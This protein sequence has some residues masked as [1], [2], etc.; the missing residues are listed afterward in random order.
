MTVAETEPDACAECG[1]AELRQD[2]DVLDTWFSSALY[3]FA[4][5]GW[6]DETPELARYYPGTVLTTARDIIFLWIARMIFSGLELIG[7]EPFRDA[8]IHSYLL[9]PEG[10][11]MSRT[12]RHRHRSRGG[13]GAVRRRRDALRAAQGD[14]E[15]GPALLVR[16][17][18]GGA[19]AREQALER[20]PAAAAG[21][22][23]G[24]GG[25]AV[26]GR[27]ALDPRADR[28]DPCRVRG[29]SRRLRLRARGP[30]ALPPHVRRLLR[31]VP[32]VDQAAPGGGGRA[33]DGVR[34]ARAAPQAPPSGDAARDRGDLDEPA[35]P[36][37]RG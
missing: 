27:G 10:K 25:A 12:H 33:R 32:R 6:P 8:V 7:E 5:L 15:P 28:R 17:D 3:P 16:H 14:V 34:G 31:L 37:A 21:R 11:R 13:A 35:G 24:A 19:E 26:V 23:R 29:G 1:S 4:T 30:A 18:R 20:E 36:R 22:R 2:E 9:N